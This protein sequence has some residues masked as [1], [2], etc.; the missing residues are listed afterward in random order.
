MEKQIEK[1]LTVVHKIKS[2]MSLVMLL[3]MVLI[4]SA[5]VVELGIVLFQEFT[6][7]TDD[8][9]L[10]EIDELF[11]IFG[12]VF[13]IL[14]GFELMETVEMYFR[15]N[16]IHAEVVLL[17]AVIA[18][19]RKVILLDLEKYDAVAI[20]GLGAIIVSLGACY[21]LIKRSGAREQ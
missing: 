20:I 4:V 15:K 5:S 13:M 6:D 3:L 18:V 8:V 7:P 17:V 11:K 2:W 10:L 1:T 12:F 9:L 21:F 16:V 19:S 14:I